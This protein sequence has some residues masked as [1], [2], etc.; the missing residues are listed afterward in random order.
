MAMAGIGK[1]GGG[2]G[3]HRKETAWNGENRQVRPGGV[4]S[5][6]SV[7]IAGGRYVNV[8]RTGPTRVRGLGGL[9][10]PCESPIP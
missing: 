3:M 2:Y 8:A 4:R 6:Q 10:G 7:M 1:Y 9:E 5:F